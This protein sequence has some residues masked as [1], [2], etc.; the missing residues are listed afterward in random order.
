MGWYTVLWYMLSLLFTKISILLL[1]L[2]ILR[3]QHARYAVYAILIIVVAT[4]GA[5]TLATVVTACT[6]LKAFWHPEMLLTSGSKASCRPTGYWLANTALHI[7]TD[8]L[9]Y[10][11]PLPVSL[12]LKM[13]ARQKLG[14]Y[15]VLVLGFGYV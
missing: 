5:W 4:N 2:R 7:A 12:K 3:Y 11:L 10:L 6:P 13:K 9:L 8:V 15:A 1:Y 14:L